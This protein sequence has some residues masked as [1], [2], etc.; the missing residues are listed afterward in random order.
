[1][2][3]PMILERVTLLVATNNL[4]AGLATESELRRQGSV[5]QLGLRKCAR[6][7]R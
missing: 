3:V 2:G 7:H 1:M 4:W 6:N 5:K